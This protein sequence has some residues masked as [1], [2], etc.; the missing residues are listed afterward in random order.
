MNRGMFI[1]QHSRSTQRK[2]SV[3]RKPRLQGKHFPA[4]L[5]HD[6]A[7]GLRERVVCDTIPGRYS[8]PWSVDA[9]EP[10]LRGEVPPA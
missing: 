9:I 8:W 2:A 1:A 5:R 3:L 4:Y 6:R 7:R 10:D